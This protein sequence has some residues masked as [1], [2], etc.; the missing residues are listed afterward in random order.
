MDPRSRDGTILYTPPDWIILTAER[1]L[2]C[3]LP[4]QNVD[5]EALRKETQVSDRWERQEATDESE[6]DYS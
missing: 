2:S 5:G 1:R 6:R 3:G 4:V